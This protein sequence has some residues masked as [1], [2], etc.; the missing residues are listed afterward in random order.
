MERTFEPFDRANGSPECAF[1]PS[2]RANGPPERTI[3][4]FDRANGPPERTVEPFD[5]A[6]DSAECANDRKSREVRRNVGATVEFSRAVGWICEASSTI[7]LLLFE[8][9]I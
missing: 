7:Q 5:R 3:E 8:W 9:L 2:D 4:P 1:E 6:N